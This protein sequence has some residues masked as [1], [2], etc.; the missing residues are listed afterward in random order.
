L[1]GARTV[2]ETR[3]GRGKKAGVV[4]RESGDQKSEERNPKLTTR[5]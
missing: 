4:T 5:G 3:Q 2:S 1:M